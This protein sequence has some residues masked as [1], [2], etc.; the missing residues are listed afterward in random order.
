MSRTDPKDVTVTRHG[1]D[2]YQAGCR[3]GT[4]TSANV[5]RIAAGDVRG[6]KG[7]AVTVS[8]SEKEIAL[9]DQIRARLGPRVGRSTL[10]RGVIL[11]WLADETGYVDDVRRAAPKSTNRQPRARAGKRQ[12]EG[13]ER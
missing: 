10:L 11:D 9:I 5:R 4:C 8:L 7:T 6:R 1:Y 3:C 2:G 13:Q 12:E